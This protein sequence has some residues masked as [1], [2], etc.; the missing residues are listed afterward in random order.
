MCGRYRLS[1]RKQIVEESFDASGAEDWNP[2]YNIAPTQPIPVMRQDPK[3]TE[4]RIVSDGIGTDS[5]LGE[6]HV[7]RCGHD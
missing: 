1:R 6:E 5:V 7:W 3:E 4:A 2:C